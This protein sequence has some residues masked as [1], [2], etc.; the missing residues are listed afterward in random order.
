VKGIY[1]RGKARGE[2]RA[3]QAL[4]HILLSCKRACR[5]PGLETI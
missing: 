4:N 5:K 2:K 1:D 3:I